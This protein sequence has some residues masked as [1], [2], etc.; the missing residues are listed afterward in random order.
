MQID[1]D[2]MQRRLAALTTPELGGTPAGGMSRLALS[3]RT[4]A[5]RATC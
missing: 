5:T 2:R 1:L 3:R 4:T